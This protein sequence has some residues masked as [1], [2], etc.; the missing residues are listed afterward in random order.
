DAFQKELQSFLASEAQSRGRDGKKRRYESLVE[1]RVRL[2]T[3]VV[4][5]ECMVDRD[6]I[7]NK[8]FDLTKATIEN[9]IAQGE[10]DATDVIA[11]REFR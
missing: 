4:R 2:A 6:S 10:K 5:I 9:L 7:S 1:G 3:E 11:K 8:M